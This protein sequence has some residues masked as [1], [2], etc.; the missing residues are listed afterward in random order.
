[1]IDDVGN[2]DA[3]GVQRVAFLGQRRRR[4]GLE[5]EMI[6]AGGNTGTGIDA[7]VIAGRYARDPCGSINAI[8]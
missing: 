8:S 6:K 3:L 2:F 4:V 5:G 7:R 1:M